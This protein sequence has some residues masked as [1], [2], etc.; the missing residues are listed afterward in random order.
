MQTQEEG[1]TI[2]SHS[3]DYW[4]QRGTN[5][6]SI[7]FVCLNTLWDEEN[8]K[9]TLQAISAESFPQTWINQLFET[10]HKVCLSQ[11][12]VSSGWGLPFGTTFGKES[13]TS[14]LGAFRQWLALIREIWP[15]ANCCQIWPTHFNWL[16]K[17][18][19]KT[20]HLFCD[21]IPQNNGN[22]HFI[23]SMQSY[24]AFK[25]ILTGSNFIILIQV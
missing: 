7:F 20:L 18:G 22:M 17:S 24:L 19:L 21:K 13:Q 25:N 4:G 9:N 14:I 2:N 5:Y 15:G 11:L 16:N 1:K 8:P 6:E 12:L 23:L 3:A 10:S